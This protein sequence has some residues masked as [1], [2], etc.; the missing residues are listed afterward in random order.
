MYDKEINFN[1]LL[2]AQRESGF[3][4]EG[5]WVWCGSAVL[6]EDN[7][8]HLFASRWPKFLPMHPGWIVG[9]E[10]VRASSDKPQGPYTFEE[11]VI[12]QRGAQY[13]D[14]RMAHNP[15]IVKH[16]GKY[17]L[18]YTGSTHPFE[19]VSSDEELRLDDKRV[20]VG[21]ANKRVGLAISNSIFGP[22]ERMDEPIL[23]TRPGK[24]DSFLTSNP[25]PCVNED[26]SVLLVY[27]ARAY[28]G[29]YCGEMTIGAAFASNYDG[30]YK[31]ISDKQIFNFNSEIEDPFVWK[32]K[33]G[34][35]LIAKDMNGGICGEIHGGI[36][37]YSKNGSD[38]FLD[39]NP[40]S[41]TRK[42]I[43]EDSSTTEF[44]SFERPFILFENGQPL[45][46]FAA[47]SDGK[48]GFLDAKNTWNLAI[49]FR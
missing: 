46:F 4:M 38:W 44:G 12:G 40:K 37:A 49:L 3:K 33:R 6:G 11:V 5:Y 15:H 2:P 21:R 31:R 39:N 43:W 34:Y 9:S 14:G 36:K 10:I 24:F 16:K 35:E 18:Y 1:N 17:L 42:V 27:K 29:N 25:A 20:M 48:N 23:K 45:C 22:W 19:D 13:W 28:K 8:Y 32:S 30:E 26:G 7:R 47:V 41:Y